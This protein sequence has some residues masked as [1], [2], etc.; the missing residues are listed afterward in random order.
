MLECG[1]IIKRPDNLPLTLSNQWYVSRL[2]PE[3]KPVEQRFHGRIPKTRLIW[4]RFAWL[5]QAMSPRPEDKWSTL[6]L[7]AVTIRMNF[8]KK[9]Q[10]PDLLQ[11]SK[12][13]FIPKRLFGKC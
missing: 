11:C 8:A 7:H 10:T 1:V 3:D 12:D 5:T 13:N 4:V 2:F 9:P 6:P